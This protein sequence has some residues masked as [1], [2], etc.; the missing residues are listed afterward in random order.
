MLTRNHDAGKGLW[1]TEMGWSSEP[2]QPN[3]S[4]AKGVAGQARELKG[5]FR[6][7][8]ANQRRWH[9][10]RVYWFSI[11]DFAGVCN[12]CGGSG[13]FANGSSRSRPG[14]LTCISPAELL[15]L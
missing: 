14:A 4:F 1:I 9:L 12:F 8:S 7:L 5:A 15:A 2:P 3:N 6:L 13:L 10:Q 11:D